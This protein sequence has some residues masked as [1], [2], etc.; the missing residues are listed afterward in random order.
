VPNSSRRG[1][2]LIQISVDVP[3][4]L[5]EAQ[6]EALLKF[7]EAMGSK[8]IQPEEKKGFFGGKKKK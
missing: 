2:Q 4:N 8:P 1:D 5:N 6:K 7:N 3:K